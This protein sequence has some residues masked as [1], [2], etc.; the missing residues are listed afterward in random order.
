MT[1]ETPLRPAI[2][3]KQPVTPKMEPATRGFLFALSAYLL[4]GFLPF[5]MK[6]V[7]HIPVAEVLA[8]R[9]VWSVPIAGA[10]LLW[11]G[12]T[13]DIRT[14]LRTPR[15]MAM[16]ALTAALITLNWGIYVWAIA[17]D[18]TLETAL[19]YYINPLISVF[20]GAVL[21]GEGLSRAQMAAIGLAVLAVAIL[22]WESGGLPWVSLALALSWGFYAFFKK[23]LPIGPA[24]GF[25]VEI[26]ILS[27][28]ALG[29]I[30]WLETRGDG[31]FG[32]TGATDVWLLLG[33]GLVTAVPLIL[34]ANGAKLLR[35]ST[36]GIMQYIAPTMIFFVA[37]FVFREPFSSERAVAFVLIWTALA[38][39]SWS[40]FAESRKH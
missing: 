26:L 20:L 1:I 10:L 2:P 6:A 30:A 15:T 3:G 18:R 21:L 29:Y 34:Y 13:S 40:M 37:V 4:W 38:I 39:Y 7:A 35:L 19:G 31:H 5:F 8:H 22:T 28:P 36:I 17:A 16:G 14:A 33:C 27:I 12:R 23:T 32:G 9:I 24:Q 25:F 11:L